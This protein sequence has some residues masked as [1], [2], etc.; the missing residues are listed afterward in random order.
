[1]QWTASA[2]GTIL[3]G[4]QSLL[5]E[6]GSPGAYYLEIMDE[7]NGCSAGAGLQVTEAEA[8]SAEIVTDSV[9]CFGE[10][11][12]AIRVIGVVGGKPPFVYALD[13]QNFQPES[14]FTNLPAGIYPVFVRD[15][16]DCIFS[17]EIEVFQPADFSVALSGDTL[18]LRGVNAQVVALVQPAGFTPAQINWTASGTPYPK[19]NFYN[20][21]HCFKTPFSRLR[22]PMKPAARC[23]TSGWCR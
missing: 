21:S 22:Y 10:E 20:R 9:R 11:N 23:P 5:V 18:V 8:I 6:V 1:M 12:G 7:G 16:N 3:N 17:N 15:A 14:E 19:I 4:A 13:N 2:G